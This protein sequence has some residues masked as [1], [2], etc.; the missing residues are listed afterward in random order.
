[1]HLIFLK[2][3]S[4]H[5]ATNMSPSGVRKR[6]VGQN[7]EIIFVTEIFS[8]HGACIPLSLLMEFDACFE[9]PN[10]LSCD[11]H[12][13]YPPKHW[14]DCSEYFTSGSD[15]NITQLNLQCI[16]MFGT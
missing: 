2:V 5:L 4:V 3:T 10:L 6:V 7:R 13:V 14:S 11:D 1:M 12:Q 15:E 9:L 8:V 16:L